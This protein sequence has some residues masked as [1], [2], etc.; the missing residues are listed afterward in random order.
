MSVA[1][2]PR[3]ALAGGR[4]HK[5]TEHWHQYDQLGMLRQ[6]NALPA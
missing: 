5:V 4:G 2:D 1:E 6:L 3:P